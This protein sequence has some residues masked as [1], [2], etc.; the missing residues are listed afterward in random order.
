MAANDDRGWFRGGFA[1]AALVACALALGT[2]ARPTADDGIGVRG[3][4]LQLRLYLDQGGS[5]RRLR[6]GDPIAPGDRIGFS[7]DHPAGY[8]MVVGTDDDGA[9]YLCYPQGGG[10]AAERVD[11]T[12]EPRPLPEAIRVD[13]TPGAERITAVL[14]DHP[15]TLEQ[16]ADPSADGA[17]GCARSVVTVVKP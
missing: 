12:P 2:L 4:G 13:A 5:S 10:G 8:L 14:C 11:A 3:S 15:F 9:P 6:D 17:A 16:L 1:A 7:V